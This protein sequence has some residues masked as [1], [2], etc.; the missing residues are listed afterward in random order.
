MPKRNERILHLGIDP[1][2]GGGL[3][4]I[5]SSFGGSVNARSM[6]AT[7]RDIWDWFESAAAW[8]E[9]NSGCFATVE[10]VQGYIG[11]AHPG[12]AMFKFGQ[13]SGKLL[14]ALTAAGIPF[15]EVTP[16]RWQKALG[17]PP[18]NK[19][20]ESKG[21]FKNRLKGFAQRI[22]PNVVGITLKTADA[23]LIA[24][25]CRRKQEGRI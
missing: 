7:D 22:F 19:Q 6:P 11:N 15:E 5:D 24:E 25:Y 9:S 3:A 16:Q 2:A 14:M 1:G 18:R 21:Q 10:K 4:S 17:I 23:L 20:K 12:N 8:A 13:S